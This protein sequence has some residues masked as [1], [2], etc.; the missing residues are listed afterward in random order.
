MQKKPFYSAEE[1]AT[2]FDV[3][4]ETIRRMCREGQIPG[5]RQIGRQWRIPANFLEA[6]QSIP[7]TDEHTKGQQK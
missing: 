5:A 1:V 2:Y 3:N 7:E 6:T 4:V